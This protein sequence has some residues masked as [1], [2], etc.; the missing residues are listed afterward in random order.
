MKCCNYFPVSLGG[1]KKKAW[2]SSERP[3]EGIWFVFILSW[4]KREISLWRISGIVS[5][6]PLNHR[7]RLTVIEVWLQNREICESVVQTF[8]FLFLF[9]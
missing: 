9:L 7:C 3:R 2:Q 8:F 6:V 4:C 5:N 1:R